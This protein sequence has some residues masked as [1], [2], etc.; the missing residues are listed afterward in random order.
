[1]TD[2][3]IPTSS[4]SSP[5]VSAVRLGFHSRYVGTDFLGDCLIAL[6]D[7]LKPNSYSGLLNR[8]SQIDQACHEHDQEIE[9]ARL[10]HKHGTYEYLR[11]RDPIDEWHRR[12]LIQLADG[13]METTRA[14]RPWY[15]FG[16]VLGDWEVQRHVAEFNAGRHLQATIHQAQKL[17]KEIVRRTKALR[18]LLASV[19]ANTE[20]HQFLEQVHCRSGFIRQLPAHLQ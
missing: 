19:T 14:L 12:A 10:D 4:A 5:L 13:A 20:P 3:P 1:M 7:D 11:N 6:V 16:A 17:R 15:D 18:V 2:N 9:A 8:I